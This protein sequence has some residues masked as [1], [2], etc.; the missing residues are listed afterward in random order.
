MLAFGEWLPD[1]PPFENPGATEAKN[2][3]PALKSY[4]PLGSLA[5][6]SDNALSG[7]CLGAGAFKTKDGD[8]YIFAGDQTKLYS[9]RGDTW[10][11]ESKPGGYSIGLDQRWRFEQFGNYIIATNGYSA[12]QK[13]D[14]T[15]GGPFHDLGGSPPTFKYQAVV[16]DF[17]VTAVVQGEGDTVRWPAM[18]NPESWGVGLNQAD[19]QI[20][21]SGGP[22]TEVFGGEYGLILQEKKI[23]RITYVGSPVVFQFDAIEENHGCWEPNS[24]AQYGKWVFY[25]SHNGFYLC[26]G[27]MARPIGDQKVDRYFFG[28]ADQMYLFNMT[29]AIDPINKLVVWAYA[30]TGHV[31]GEPNKLI[32]YN[33]AIDRW[34]HAEIT[35]EYLLT[36]MSP[37]LTLEGLDEVSEDLDALPFSLDSTIWKGGKLLLGAFGTSHKLQSFSGANLAATIE[38][39]EGEP[40]AGTR[41]R[42][43]FTR[44]MVD[45][46]SATVQIGHRVRLADAVVWDIA[47][48]MDARGRAPTRIY[49]RYLRAR[50]NIP[51]AANWTHAQ[52]VDF[53]SFDGG[54][55]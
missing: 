7:R 9:L 3:Y 13:Y 31:N 4:R 45:V 38:T 1:L 16:R 20:L 37:G 30:G 46:A 42:I 12:P 47:K 39:L 26:D 14:V 44:P 53:I 28:D 15:T 49:N 21:P 50:V 11:D 10:I 24:A 2:V 41:T 34:S 19:F 22:I 6:V 51:A 43:R 36:A 17:L 52:G 25:L 48:A 5:D 29:A 32:I 8:V 40:T 33:W 18:N 23:T 54:G 35:L 55:R 27:T